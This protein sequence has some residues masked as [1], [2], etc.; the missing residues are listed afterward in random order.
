MI[1]STLRQVRPVLAAFALPLLL[2]MYYEG[3]AQSVPNV[4]TAES[5]ARKAENR[6]VGRDGRFE[7]K[8]RLF[9]RQQRVRERD[10]TI[11]TMR[12]AATGAR[13]AGSGDR[14]LIRFTYPNDIRDTAFLVWEH[15]GADD[16]RFLYL[17]ALGRVRR[18]AGAETQDS[19]V[20]SDFTYEDISGREFDSYTYAMV[21]A[22]ADVD[23]SGRPARP[24]LPD[25]VA[26]PRCAGA[27]SPHR[28]DHPQGQLRRRARRHLQP[29]ERSREGLRRPPARTDPVD[30]DALGNRDDEHRRADAHR[31]H[32][33]V[34]PLQHRTE[35][36]GLQPERAGAKVAARDPA[37]RARCSSHFLTVSCWKRCTTGFSSAI[38]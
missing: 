34:G 1:V 14:V 23:R 36:S 24:G 27:V 19:F 25:R 20:G 26:R 32:D 6:D 12:P 29:P 18:I 15:P 7:L 9:D 33:E 17:P 30:L 21:E 28:V 5:V 4:E 35:G 10:L 16:E 38:G 11:L 31:A 22:D 37:D 8:M 3:G 13:T 2:T